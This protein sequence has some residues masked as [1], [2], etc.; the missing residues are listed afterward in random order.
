M[1]PAW[2]LSVMRNKSGIPRKQLAEII[3]AKAEFLINTQINVAHYLES[4]RSREAEAQ[5]MPTRGWRQR[6]ARSAVF[7]DA[8]AIEERLAS[9]LGNQCIQAY[10]FIEEHQKLL[11]AKMRQKLFAGRPKQCKRTTKPR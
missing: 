9:R 2:G 11:P 5:A 4:A 7:R 8:V 3:K 1:V 10:K 6:D